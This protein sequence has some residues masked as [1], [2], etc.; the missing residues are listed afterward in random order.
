[1]PICAKPVGL[2]AARAFLAD[3]QAHAHRCEEDV[4][5]SGAGAVLYPVAASIANFIDCRLSRL[6][7]P[8]LEEES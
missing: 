1:M 7:P 8:A 3:L 6:D 5:T 4:R 2:S